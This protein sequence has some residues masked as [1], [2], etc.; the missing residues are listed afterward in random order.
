MSTLG[1]GTP[2]PTSAAEDTSKHWV[3]H[4]PVL[5]ASVVG[6]NVLMILLI[7][8]FLWRFFSGKRGPS[9]SADADADD[10]ASS[11]A[12]LPV[13]SPWANRRR[14]RDLAGAQPL[15]ADVASTLPVY[16]YS[17][18]AADGANKAA[19]ESECAVCIVELRDGEPARRLPRCGHQFHAG[20]VGEWLRL[21]DTCPLCRAT[22]VAPAATTGAVSDESRNA[23][24]DEDVSA[25]D[26]PV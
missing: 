25:A 1:S 3:A 26:C 5:T 10:D 15:D 23:K 9:A 17:S 14:C 18:A 13:A 21:H 7:F 16:A 22:V 19:A 6:V 8:F 24:D 11:S 2:S 4:G 12:S 20:C